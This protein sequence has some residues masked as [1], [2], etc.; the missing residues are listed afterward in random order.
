[1]N[2]KSSTN[3][4][5][6]GALVLLAMLPGCWFGGARD[7]KVEER[8]ENYRVQDEAPVAGDVIVTMDG[9]PLITKQMVE[10]QKERIMKTSPQFKAM[11]AA[12][13]NADQVNQFVAQNMV[14]EKI[15]GKYIAD[16][17]IDKTAEYKDDIAAM[18]SGLKQAINIKHFG[19][20][21]PVIISEAELR[22]FYD[23][24]KAMLMTSPGGVTAMMVQFDNEPAARSFMATVKQQKDDF[25]KAANEAGLSDKV[26]EFKTI[27]MRTPGIDPMLRDKI[28]AIKQTP[29][30]E[31]FT[32]NGVSWVVYATG[33]EAPQ[34]R[35]FEQV[36]DGIKH[37]LEQQKQAE[38]LSKEVE[39]L[40]EKYKIELDKNFFKEQAPEMEEEEEEEEIEEVMKKSE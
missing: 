5:F 27:T 21:F 31:L 33:K 15:I 20:K 22:D 10:V 12:E 24:N 25:K 8:G 16:E 14:G 39:N 32:V 2:A 36:K 17:G 26:K 34:Y 23:K 11:M 7:Q 37:Q 18:E 9:K 1:M 19:Q 38:V 3:I 6:G 13:E 4:S 30:L 29:T 40:K 35:P 28:I